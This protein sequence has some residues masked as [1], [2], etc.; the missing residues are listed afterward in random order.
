MGLSDLGSFKFQKRP[1]VTAA[2][3]GVAFART[4]GGGLPEC[5]KT[6][7]KGFALAWFHADFLAGAN[8]E[9]GDSHCPP[10]IDPAVLQIPSGQKKEGRS[11]TM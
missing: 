11:W 3:S 8:L 10:A 9:N 5:S 1:A 2:R 7:R 4:A 6:R